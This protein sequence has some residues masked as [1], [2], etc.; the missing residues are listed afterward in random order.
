MTERTNQN[1]EDDNEI[2][3]GIGS[4]VLELYIKEE[5]RIKMN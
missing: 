4:G 1:Y 2:L 3:K 5:K